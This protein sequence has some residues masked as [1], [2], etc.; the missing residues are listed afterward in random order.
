[1]QTIL[2]LVDAECRQQNFLEA[3]NILDQVPQGR[4]GQEESCNLLIAKTR[5][6]RDIGV[7]E[8][9]ISLLRKKIEFVADSR[10]R[11]RLTLELAECYILTK[12]YSLARRE[13]NNVLADMPDSY[14]AR[15]ASLVLAQIIEKIGQP[16]RA[17]E[18]CL[19]VL[20]DPQVEENIRNEA[21]NTLGRIYTG[22]K[23]YEKA[24]LAFAGILPQG[25]G[26]P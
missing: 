25:A 14:H 18:L 12:D 4:F 10:L 3:M 2:E 17:E 20:S 22:Q 1:M 24:A 26:M 9:A 21:F 11:A 7:V 23:Y 19:A 6:L 8:S 16:S 13:L 15:R 5:I